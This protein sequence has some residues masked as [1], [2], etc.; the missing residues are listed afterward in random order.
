MNEAA[1]V[2][3]I[4]GLLEGG[5]GRVILDLPT[6]TLPSD[7]SPKKARRPF[8]KRSCRQRLVG[9]K[10]SFTSWTCLAR[11]SACGA[12]FRGVS[13]LHGFEALMCVNGP[14]FLALAYR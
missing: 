8:P 1:A 4:D 9:A 6:A 5:A 7:R 3:L 11:Q 12:T 2:R 13:A 10:H 14:P